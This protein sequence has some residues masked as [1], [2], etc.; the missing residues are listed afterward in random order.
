MNKV[1]V[2]GV[3]KSI[4]G[5]KW[6]TNKAPHVLFQL[7]ICH[8]N[9]SGKIVHEKYTVNVW[10]DAAVWANENLKQGQPIIIQGYLTQRSVNIGASEVIFAE[11]TAEKI[12]ICELMKKTEKDESVHHEI[13][14]E[15]S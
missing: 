10:N 5:M 14:V 1:F 4:P 12:T 8:K 9:R 6:E 13:P 15:I 3:V 2:S 7:D 11:I